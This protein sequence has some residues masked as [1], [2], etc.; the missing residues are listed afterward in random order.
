MSNTQCPTDVKKSTL[1]KISSHR[2]I[3][4]IINDYLYSALITVLMNN[5]LHQFFK[6]YFFLSFHLTILS[7]KELNTWPLPEVS[8]KLIKEI[9]TLSL[10]LSLIIITFF[11]FSCRFQFNI[12]FFLLAIK[13]SEAYYKLKVRSHQFC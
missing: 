13:S 9:L 10:Q 6:E 12:V 4:C 5:F 2:T 1:D 11:F 7:L 3:W 8:M